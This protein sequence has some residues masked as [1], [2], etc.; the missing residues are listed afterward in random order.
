[1]RVFTIEMLVIGGLYVLIKAVA[2]AG[3]ERRPARSALVAYLAWPGVNPAPFTG[4]RAV[5][6][7]PFVSPR[8]AVTAPSRGPRAMATAPFASPRAAVTGLFAGTRPAD[9]TRR[10]LLVMAVGLAGG[11]ALAVAAP[12]LDR[13]VVGW[14]GIAAILT[15]VHLG[16]SDVLTGWFGRRYPVSRLFADPLASRSLREFWSLRWNTAYVEM[17]RVVFGPLARRWFGRRANAG[18]FLISGLLHEAAISVPV[19]AGFGGPTAYFLLHAVAVHAEPRIGLA[20]WPA[21]LARL[22]TWCWILAPLP[23]LFHT[24]FRDALVA[25]LFTRWSTP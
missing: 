16:F 21:P 23:L 15:T 25:P 6:T 8:V 5:A 14:L 22:W 18:I 9:L 3:A 13:A 19:L 12:H 24:A 4:P 7:P 10:G 20:R 11:A 2:F 17:N 1:M